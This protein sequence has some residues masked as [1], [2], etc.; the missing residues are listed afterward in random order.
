MVDLSDF[1]DPEDDEPQDA[2]DDE[3]EAADLIALK[4]SLQALAD[5][6][7]STNL[8]VFHAIQGEAQGATTRVAASVAALKRFHDA[9]KVLK[10]EAEQDE[11]EAEEE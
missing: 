2:A 11:G 1:I 5:A 3:A 9:F 8:A 10:G 4:D 6:I 7:A